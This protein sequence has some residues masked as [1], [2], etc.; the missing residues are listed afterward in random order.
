M[1]RESSL[2]PARGKSDGLVKMESPDPI[3]V[4]PEKRNE[5]YG[6]FLR[7]VPKLVEKQAQKGI[8]GFGLEVV[9]IEELES[10]RMVGREW[11]FKQPIPHNYLHI[12]SF[13]GNVALYLSE[14]RN[15]QGNIN[16][17]YF[18]NDNLI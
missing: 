3:T 17:D 1:K 16:F 7:W 15:K 10:G 2:S 9:C 4:V 6:E 18:L 5:F 13:E 12:V 8:L 11:P 14:T